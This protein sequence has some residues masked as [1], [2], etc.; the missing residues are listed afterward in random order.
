MSI[1]SPELYDERTEGQGQSVSERR[2]LLRQFE[3]RIRGVFSQ[4]EAAT[5]FGMIGPPSPQD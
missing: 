4:E 2:E 5:I 3:N 1:A